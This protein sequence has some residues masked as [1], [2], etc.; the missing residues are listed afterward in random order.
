MV[1]QV[2]VPHRKTCLKSPIRWT[3]VAR[4]GGGPLWCRSSTRMTVPLRSECSPRH[5]DGMHKQEGP[6]L[7]GQSRCSKEYSLDAIPR[8]RSSFSASRM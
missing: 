4:A 7:S 3:P 2:V 8:E 5:F 1:N 6:I